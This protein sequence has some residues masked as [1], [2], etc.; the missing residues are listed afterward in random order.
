[1]RS[2]FAV[3]NELDTRIKSRACQNQGFS[4]VR[5]ML[6]SVPA[7]PLVVLH[8]KEGK[9]VSEKKIQKRR[10]KQDVRGTQERFMEGEKMLIQAGQQGASEANT[11][12]VNTPV[13]NG[14]RRGMQGKPF[15]Y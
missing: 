9:I 11:P 7:D 1:M 2:K 5:A 12:L 4:C 3:R 6:H 15:I 13:V 14:A 8:T 10:E